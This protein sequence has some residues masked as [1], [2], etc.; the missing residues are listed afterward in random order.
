MF[1]PILS[2]DATTITADN[3]V[4]NMTDIAVT[5]DTYIGE[6]YLDNLY[7]R[8]GAKVE[9]L[10]NMSYS[11]IDVTG[12]TLQA[13]NVYM[14]GKVNPI[15]RFA[16]FVKGLFTPK[17]GQLAPMELSVQEELQNPEVSDNTIT[18]D[19]RFTASSPLTSRLA[20]TSP[21]YFMQS[22]SPVHLPHSSI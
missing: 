15:I 7:V 3:T 4:Y 8:N 9:T 18:K 5:G 17:S 14:V 1:L 6:H 16:R 20:F 21:L 2:N 13:N 10:D 11:F 19:D 12:G 22:L